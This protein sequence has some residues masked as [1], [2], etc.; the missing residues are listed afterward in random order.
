[1]NRK[2]RVR[3]YRNCHCSTRSTGIAN[4]RRD[5]ETYAALSLLTVPDAKPANTPPIQ[6]TASTI[7]AIVPVISGVGKLMVNV[8]T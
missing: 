1:M 5:R 4:S 7:K 3:I 6:T 2:A 8:C